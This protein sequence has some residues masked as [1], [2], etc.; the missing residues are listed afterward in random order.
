MWSYQDHFQISA[1]RSA[2]ILFNN[3]L[4]DLDTSLFLVGIESND[5]E[6]K[7]KICIEPN[8]CPIQ[9]CNFEYIIDEQERIIELNPRSRMCYS[10]PDAAKR[11]HSRIRNE[12]LARAIEKRCSE[13][14]GQENRLFLAS[15]PTN[16]DCYLVS[17]VLSFDRDT[18]ESYQVL[19]DEVIYDW[20]PDRSLI[21]SIAHA[22][23]QCCRNALLEEEPG[24]N[25][26]VIDATTEELLRR[27]G[28]KF[29]ESIGR[30]AFNLQGMANAF[31]LYGS[32]NAISAMHYE[33]SIADGRFI[34]RGREGI[35]EIDHNI[36]FLETISLRESRRLRKLLELT[37]DDYSLII[38]DN[39]VIGITDKQSAQS[40]FSIDIPGHQHWRML[41]NDNIICEFRYG[42]P[43]LPQSKLEKQV[44]AELCT[45]ILPADV[46]IDKLWLVTEACMKQSH[47]TTMVVSNQAETESQRLSKQSTTIIPR[48]LTGKDVTAVTSIDGAI[49]LDHKGTCHSIGVILDGCATNEGDPARGARFNSAIRYLNFHGDCCIILVVS[50]DGDVTLLPKLHPRI[51]RQ[52]VEDAVVALI[53]AANENPLRRRVYAEALNVLETLG[54]YLSPEQCEKINHIVEAVEKRL[55]E[56]GRTVKITRQEFIPSPEMDDTYFFPD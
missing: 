38:D 19:P 22:F 53:Q 5:H 39:G 15:N 44:F 23:L 42:T 41:Y 50:E 9:P 47:G 32:M 24:L 37:R 28:Q 46:D 29:I 34:L 51:N 33:G 25:G 27:G 6:D 43:N 21:Q 17:C 20:R 30:R 18:Y 10:N 14:A 55:D 40:G 1:K 8:H 36:Q 16:V 45:R 56:E 26:C 49:L 31:G 2:E 54:F 3:L 13:T 12:S 35:Q 11:V 52:T 7:L 48:E 4:P